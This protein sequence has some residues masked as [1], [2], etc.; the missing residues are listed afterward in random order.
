MM[1][2]CPNGVIRITKPQPDEPTASDDPKG[3]FGK[4]GVMFGA[5]DNSPWKTPPKGPKKQED[6]TSA[7]ASLMFSKKPPKPTEK[8]VGSIE[9]IPLPQ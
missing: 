2:L 1:A 9:N 4:V 7:Q 6:D 8:Q 3:S 5:I